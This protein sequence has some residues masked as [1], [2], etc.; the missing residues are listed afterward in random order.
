M[1]IPR[2]RKMKTEM[3]LNMIKKKK[4]MNIT[5]KKNIDVNNITA[6]KR[7]KN[8]DITKKKRNMS[9]NIMKRK[10]R[11]MIIAVAFITMKK[12]NDSSYQ[13]LRKLKQIT[14]QQYL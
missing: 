5:K 8:I 3:I 12:K 1:C 9:I 14:K 7:M 4:D 11:S 10:M 2:Y 13:K 6:K